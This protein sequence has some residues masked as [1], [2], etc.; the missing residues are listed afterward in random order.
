MHMSVVSYT[1]YTVGLCFTFHFDAID[2]IVS[3][4]HNFV[5]S[6]NLTASDVNF[7]CNRRP[8]WHDISFITFASLQWTNESMQFH[9][10]VAPLGQRV[11][12]PQVDCGLVVG[13][14]I[15]YPT[16]YAQFLQ[17]SWRNTNI[18]GNAFVTKATPTVILHCKAFYDPPTP[19]P[20]HHRNPLVGW[21]GA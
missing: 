7:Q 11:A 5:L 18:T 14:L 6:Q 13:L 20:L 8:S 21:D 15:S 9:S 16:G 1:V 4:C 19:T 17:G 10:G 2:G 3:S 12:T